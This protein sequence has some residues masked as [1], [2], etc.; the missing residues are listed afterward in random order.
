MKI[1]IG[2]DG[3]PASDAAIR[4]VARLAPDEVNDIQLYFSASHL[5][6]TLR[7]D[8]P[9]LLCE[10]TKKE[11][12][13]QLFDHA[14]EL[15]P[16]HLREVTRTVVGRQAP[17]A[18]LMAAADRFQPEL[19][20]V[21]ASG[22]GRLGRILIGGVSK[23]IALN[24]PVPVLVGRRS[25]RVELTPL[26]V[27]LAYGHPAEQD[28]RKEFLLRLT[29]PGDTVARAIHVENSGLV[30]EVPD[31]LRQQAQNSTDEPF[32]K[33]WAQTEQACLE[34]DERETEAYCRDL[35]PHLRTAT[36]IV[37]TGNAGQEIVRHAIDGQV[38]LV[39]L[40]GPHRHSRWSQFSL[41]GTPDY[42]LSHAPCSVL[43]IPHHDI[44]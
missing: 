36:A 17:A 35:P 40:S 13:N 15:L 14:R 11:I 41:G 16:Q 43:L 39:I 31:W 9:E 10:A 12:V 26:R 28:D 32:A 44:P 42:V 3:S 7:S 24:A 27:L 8:A 37:A 30:P 25:E 1:L 18:G 22:L 33:Q 4:L 6:R 34:R 29:W 38:D 20:A 5:D 23:T 19:I 2:V 21:G